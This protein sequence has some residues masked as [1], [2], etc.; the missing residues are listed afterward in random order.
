MPTIQSTTADKSKTKGTRTAS[1]KSQ[2]TTKT[3]GK[4]VTP[5][6]RQQMIAEAAYFIAEHRGFSGNDS[7]S[8]WF[9]A[10]NQIDQMLTHQ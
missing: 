7:E 10:E 2:K 9:Y 1:A 6:Q 4:F 8:D 5:E 3:A